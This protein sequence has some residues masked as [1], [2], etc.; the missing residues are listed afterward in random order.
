MFISFCE[1]IRNTRPD[2]RESTV[3]NC[4]FKPQNVNL[5]ICL[6]KKQTISCVIGTILKFSWYNVFKFTHGIFL[7]FVFIISKEK[8]RTFMSRFLAVVRNTTHS[9]QTYISITWVSDKKAKF[10]ITL[11]FRLICRRIWWQLDF[12]T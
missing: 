9:T 12:K 11:T 10:A 6:R 2:R 4:R 5:H 8:M 7:M 1:H 3:I